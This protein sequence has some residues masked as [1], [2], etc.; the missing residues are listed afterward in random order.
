MKTLRQP[1]KSISAIFQRV[2]GAMLALVTMLAP[3]ALTGSAQAPTFTLLYAFTGGTDGRDPIAGLIMDAQGNLYGAAAE[4]GNPAC[5]HGC[6]TIFK[7]DTTGKE[8]VLYSFTGGDGNYPATRLVRDAQGNLY[9]TTEIGAAS[10]YGTV[11][12]LDPFGNETI[13]H[14]FAGGGDGDFPSDLIMDDQANLYGTTELGGDPTCNGGSGCGTVFEVDNTGRETVLYSFT[15]AGGDGQRPLAGLVRNAQGDLYG[16]TAL[17]GASNAGTIFRVDATG[18]ETV[19]HSFNV[20]DGYLPMSSLVRDAQGN[21]YGATYSGGKGFE[22]GN[23]VVFKLNKTGKET[24]LYRFPA[25]GKRGY[26]PQ[27]GLVR[28]GQGNL[29]GTTEYGGIFGFGAVFK[30]DKT[31]KQTLLYSFAGKQADGAN[32][33]AGLVQDAEGNLYGTTT[34]G[35]FLSG[36]VFKVAP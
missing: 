34:G 6:G 4:G 11:F 35:S 21:L 20:I 19:L 36:T 32:P 23:G 14:S 13:L 7:L 1:Q 15:Q 28:D 9:G 26:H 25:S 22:G 33:S 8:T 31:G 16:T 10:G 27:D 24:V 2:T 30:V 17:G 5:L 18:K 29:Y 3:A 12:K